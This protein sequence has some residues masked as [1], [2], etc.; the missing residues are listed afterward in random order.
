MSEW[1]QGLIHAEHCHD[2]GDDS[3]LAEA[4]MWTN[5][6]TASDFDRGVISFY[7]E[8]YQACRKAVQP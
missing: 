6:G 7:D 2:N 3:P 5:S 4:K 8:A 1:L